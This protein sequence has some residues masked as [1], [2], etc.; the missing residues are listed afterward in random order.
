MKTSLKLAYF[1]KEAETTEKRPHKLYRESLKIGDIS[2]RKFQ[3]LQAG[4]LQIVI[5]LESMVLIAFANQTS[6]TYLIKLE[7]RRRRAYKSPLPRP[8]EEYTM[9]SEK[10]FLCWDMTAFLIVFCS[11]D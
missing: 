7:R 4:K 8:Y 1:L 3:V 9:W 2:N 6:I 10:G 11:I 5:K